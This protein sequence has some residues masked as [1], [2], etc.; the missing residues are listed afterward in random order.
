MPRVA[1]PFGGDRWIRHQGGALC[2][3]V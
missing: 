1:A 3:R 2:V